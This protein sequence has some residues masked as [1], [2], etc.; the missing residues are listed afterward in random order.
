MIESNAHKNRWQIA[1]QQSVRN[2][3]KS[4]T[5]VY[6]TEGEPQIISKGQ[7]LLRF[8][9]GLTIYLEDDILILEIRPV[10]IFLL[11]CFR[12]IPLTG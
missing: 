12:S 8:W 6:K 10:L 5:E 2:A 4:Y 3:Q 9:S 11:L 1:E 7:P